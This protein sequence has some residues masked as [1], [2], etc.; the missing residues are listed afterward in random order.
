MNA[1]GLDSS[2][3]AGS[4]ALLRDSRVMREIGSPKSESFSR[5]LLVTLEELLRESGLSLS[6]ID[7]FGVAT[8]PGSFTGIRIGVSTVF[9]IAFPLG[10]P[11]YGISTLEAMARSA[12]PSEKDKTV[13]PLLD[14][15][16]GN[17]YTACFR[18]REKE[19][20]RISEDSIQPVETLPEKTERGAAFFGDLPET[21]RKKMEEAGIFTDRD[22]FRKSVAA[23]AAESAMIMKRKGN[24]GD[25][26]LLKPNYI[27]R[28]PV[29]NI[30]S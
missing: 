26:F 1:V 19:L 24:I 3:G 16:R 20:K 22:I 27:H 10:K 8:G 13:C 7:C 14:A 12:L 2:T 18:L 30:Y 17:V 6:D 28:G 15:G 4:V 29:K 21:C 9:G 11:V 25:V 23:G 5:S